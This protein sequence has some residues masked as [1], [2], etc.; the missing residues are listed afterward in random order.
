MNSPIKEEE[1]YKEN[2]KLKK[3][4]QTCEIRSRKSK[5]QKSKEK[6]NL[7]TKLEEKN[8][9]ENLKEVEAQE[10]QKKTIIRSRKD[11]K[12]VLRKRFGKIEEKIDQDKKEL[13][14]L[15]EKTNNLSEKE[16]DLEEEDNEFESEEEENESEEEKDQS[17]ICEDSDIEDE[18][19]ELEE[20]KPKRRNKVIEEENDKEE[21]STEE[22]EQESMKEKEEDLM[23]EENLDHECGGS[24]PLSESEI[25]HLLTIGMSSFSRNGP[26]K[27]SIPGR[28][29]EHLQ[30]KEIIMS[31]VQN[32]RGVSLLVTGKPGTGKTLLIDRVVSELST[33]KL[34]INCMDL[35]NSKIFETILF[36]LK[37]KRN[38]KEMNDE[39]IIG[40]LETMFINDS[41]KMYIVILDEI[42]KLLNSTKNLFE[43]FFQ[44]TKNPKSKLIL[45]GISNSSDL[46]MKTGSSTLF[47]RVNFLPYTSKQITQ[48]LLE[49]VKLSKIEGFVDIKAIEFIAKK[50]ENE[51][52][53]R[54]ALDIMKKSI[55]LML[56]ESNEYKIT[57]PHVN[58]V[59]KDY[60][61]S[62]MINQIK[63][64]QFSS[65]YV[66]CTIARYL[67]DVCQGKQENIEVQ[68]LFS[69]QITMI[70][71]LKLPQEFILPSNIFLDGFERLKEYGIIQ[72]HKK[73][74]Y[75][76]ITKDDIHF[77]LKENEKLSRILNC[78]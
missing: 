45:I 67:E 34:Y 77:A 10:N 69:Y 64:C 38:V 71:K 21:D 23:E 27:S 55:E 16:N 54:M 8:F 78:L 4:M 73:K 61:V 14:E 50:I 37:S 62:P 33:K 39:E 2:L 57:T 65:Q 30:I 49:R 22:K 59:F 47:K 68:K 41:Q 24:D 9:Q 25:R 70:K 46:H 5:L 26:S 56:N 29:N 66:L 43:I 28:E 51:G 35:T 48:I 52:D 53:L 18:P 3:K 13:E 76:H 63:K 60:L 42:E 1:E 17:F 40:A 12:E 32:N 72:I 7:Q 20:K 15:K 44:W 74:H 11:R 75:L 6:E 58:R 36:H 31:S 19:L